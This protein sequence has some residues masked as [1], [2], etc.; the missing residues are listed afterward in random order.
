MLLEFFS[1]LERGIQTTAQQSCKP[2]V[3]AA[4]VEIEKR[5]LSDLLALSVGFRGIDWTGSWLLLLYQSWEYC[6]F[7]VHHMVYVAHR[8]L[9]GLHE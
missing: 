3:R 4:T 8:P 9:T 7:I 5:E 1:I 2:P 6:R